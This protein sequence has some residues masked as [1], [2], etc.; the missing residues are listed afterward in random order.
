M[1]D[2]FESVC[3]VHHG[4]KSKCNM[5]LCWL[6]FWNRYAQKLEARQ[7][8]DQVCIVYACVKCMHVLVYDV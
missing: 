7:L 5:F 8:V 1:L 6:Q 2:V 3:I 4:G